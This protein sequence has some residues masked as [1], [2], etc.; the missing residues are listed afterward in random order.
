MDVILSFLFYVTN[1]E[2]INCRHIPLKVFAKYFA[3]QDLYVKLPL[4]HHKQKFH[5]LHLGADL[6]HQV[7]NTLFIDPITYYLNVK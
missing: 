4:K 7:Q 3:L 2:M 5:P 6:I 1:G